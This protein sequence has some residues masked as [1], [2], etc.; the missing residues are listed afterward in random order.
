M[1]V[2]PSVLVF[3]S[4]ELFVVFEFFFGDNEC[5]YRNTRM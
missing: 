2:C 1:K 4:T 5:L 3:V